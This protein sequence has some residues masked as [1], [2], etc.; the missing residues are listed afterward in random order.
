[1]LEENDP[2]FNE[3]NQKELTNKIMNSPD[4][5]IY[6]VSRFSDN[7]LK[8]VG[9]LAVV[10]GVVD[11]IILMLLYIPTISIVIIALDI[12]ILIIL[13]LIVSYLRHAHKYFKIFVSEYGVAKD[14]EWYGGAIP[15]EKLEY[16]E[17][18]NKRNRIDFIHFRSGLKKI[19]YRSSFLATR[20]SLDVVSEYIGGLENWY[21]VDEFGEASELAKSDVYYMNPEID[22]T[23]GQKRL[24][25]I[26][27]MEWIGEQ[28]F[29]A[30]K[31]EEQISYKSDEQLYV[32]I[33]EDPR[34]ESLRD[35]GNFSRFVGKNK[36]VVFMFFL[37]IASTF[38]AMFLIPY[39]GLI[40]AFVIFLFILMF[41]GMC[42]GDEKLVMS[43]IGIARFIFGSPEAL[44]WQHIEYIDLS[45]EEDKL[46]QAE[47]FGNQRRIFL[48]R[49]RYKDKITMNK[50]RAYLP[51]IDTWE[52]KTRTHWGP[53]SYRLVR[54]K[55]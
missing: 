37:A 6:G 22:R 15:W 10:L 47:F 50:I 41:Y 3:D 40:F 54:P 46:V 13:S 49:H 14:S 27:L 24:E 4:C 9:I 36:C 31:T 55:E 38:S 12:I 29:D 8:N 2:V 19:G 39:S 23:E 35:S 51:E 53:D 11:I 18:K 30:Y 20:L 25:D 17:V 1:M 5:R 7:T 32:L 28:E 44:E 26:I 42:K 16:I 34:C 48:P 33:Q 21:I 45:F 52:K 43:P